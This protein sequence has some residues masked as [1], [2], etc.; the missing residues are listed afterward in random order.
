[1]YDNPEPVTNLRHVPEM[2]QE[3][4]RQYLEK[5]GSKDA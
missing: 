4:H 2:I 5:P 1:M 3:F